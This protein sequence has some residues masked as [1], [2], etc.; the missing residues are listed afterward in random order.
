MIPRYNTVF[1]MVALSITL[2]ACSP[3]QFAAKTDTPVV[4]NSPAIGDGNTCTVDAIM[5]PTR[6]LF[7]VDT[8]G[9]NVDRTSWPG[10]PGCESGYPC[11]PPTD[12]AKNFRYGALHDF[13]ARYRHKTNF[14]WGFITFSGDRA[15][16][17]IHSGSESQPIFGPPAL[18]E[19]AL[20]S[21]Y[22]ER[23]QGM[24]PYSPALSLARKAVLNDAKRPSAE[25][26]QYFIILLTDGFPTD[27]L[28]HYNQ[29]NQ[30][31]LNNDIQSLLATAPDQ[32][33]LSAIFYGQVMIP[34][35]V[36]LLQG[37]A[38]KG[39]GHFSTVQNPQAGFR[40]EDVITAPSASCSGQ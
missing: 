16:A 1:T 2:S 39:G 7:V 9:S 38:Y 36:S 27:Y 35:A 8:S 4:P 3:V 11:I 18:L 5:R 34:Q 6:L 25:T 22:F 30:A 19:S 12:P 33:R 17:L 21:F 40:I 28:D 31:A 14:D 37:I 23:D 13:L 10:V 15:R 20:N 32:V 26:P 24:T 29:F